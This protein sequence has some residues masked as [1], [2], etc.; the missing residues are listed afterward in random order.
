MPL[1]QN[2]LRKAVVERTELEY[3]VNGQWLPVIVS[4]FNDSSS[5]APIATIQL[6]TVPPGHAGTIHPNAN[7]IEHKLR[8]KGTN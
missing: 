8:I 3:L 7:D 1:E 6:L 5:H 4:G 2:Q